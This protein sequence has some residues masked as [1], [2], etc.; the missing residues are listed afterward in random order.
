MTSY[1]MTKKDVINAETSSIALQTLDSG[2]II[3]IKGAAVTETT[4]AE[5]GEFRN[6]GY[7][8]CTDGQIYGSVSATAIKSIEGIIEL[9]TDEAENGVDKLEIKVIKR[10]SNAGREFISLLIM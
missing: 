2:A 5:T 10:K 6:V 8:V 4:D 1:G 3:E 7:M 9:F